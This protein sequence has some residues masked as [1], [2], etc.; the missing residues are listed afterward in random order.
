VT[1]PYRS[2]PD[3]RWW[4]ALAQTAPFDVDPVTAWPFRI[5]R[6][7]RVVAAGSCFAQHLSRELR[8]RGFTLLVTEPAH[9]LVPEEIA[10]ACQYGVYSARYGNIYTTRQLLQLWRRAFGSFVPHEDVWEHQGRYIDP[11]RPTIQPD[12]FATLREYQA[13]RRQHFAAVRQ[14]FRNMDVFMFTLGLTESWISRLDG[15]VFPIC[16]GVVAGEFDPA[17]HA[18]VNLSCAEVVADMTT[19]LAE[20]RDI[21]PDVRVILTLS[22]VPLVVTAE[23]RHVL[24]SNTWS[25]AV[26]RVA[27]EEVA[28]QCGAAYFPAY[29][30]VT[31]AFS[32]GAYLADDLR[33]IRPE[34]MDHVTRL[35]L[36]HA[37]ELGADDAPATQENAAAPD[38]FVPQV[39]AM[40]DA[41]CDDGRLEQIAR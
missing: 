8:A 36:R 9:P 28:R 33:S 20:L 10:D 5:K 25:Q 2:A 13:D 40:V 30:I 1:H 17:R 19:F 31:G 6:T 41:V 35:F 18:F 15:A 22:P 29:E 34:G 21:N 23:D 38:A 32:R 37:T 14:A 26:L 12:G 39:S 7:D 4:R 11:F 3:D 27:A 16:P 24:V